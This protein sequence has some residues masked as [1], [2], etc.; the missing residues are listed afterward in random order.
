[1]FCPNCG[2]GENAP[3]TYC[4][5]CG[6]F[7]TDLSG[8]TSLINR[9]IGANTPEKRVNV[10]LSFDA[11]TLV[12]SSL[13]LVFLFG[14][15]DGRYTR[16]GE[17]APPIIYFV[18]AF[19]GFT[20]IWQLLSLIVGVSHKNKLRGRNKDNTST[21]DKANE[22]ADSPVAANNLLPPADARNVVPPSVAENTT[23]HLDKI[24]RE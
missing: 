6:T 4:R 7:L 9:I 20:A 17:A 15:F 1:M 19:L 11:L 16:T 13:L 3:D 24:P 21:G 14:Y 18:Y 12:F 10:G 22:I 8:N 23:R 2:K 5:N